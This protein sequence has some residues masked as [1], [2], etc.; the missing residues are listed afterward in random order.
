MNRPGDGVLVPAFF[1]LWAVLGVGSALFFWLNRDAALKRKVFPPL[2][3]GA[4][5]IFIGFIWLTGAPTQFLFIAIPA[6]VLISFLNIRGMKFCDSCGR[7]IH[8]QNPFS[9]AEFCSKCGA[10]LQ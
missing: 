5:V 1:V 7:T 6:V 9:P 10:K 2:M 4:G 8:S 3:I